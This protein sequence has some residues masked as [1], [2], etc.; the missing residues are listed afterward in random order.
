MLLAK[1]T[2]ELGVYQ[3]PNCTLLAH[4][5][6]KAG[7]DANQLYNALDFSITTF[8]LKS[9]VGGGNDDERRGYIPLLNALEREVM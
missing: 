4:Y 3:Y 5:N 9:H 6:G 2:I 1:V 8:I 7:Q